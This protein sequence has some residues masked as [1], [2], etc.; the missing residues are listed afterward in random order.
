MLTEHGIE[1]EK[2]LDLVSQLISGGGQTAVCDVVDYTPRSRRILELSNREAMRFRA[3]TI[4]TEHLLIALLR[5][6]DCVAV[7]LL[8]TMGVNIQKL[9]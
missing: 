1:E 2:V 3:S 5:E 8:T 7:R 9:Y 4:G 6:S